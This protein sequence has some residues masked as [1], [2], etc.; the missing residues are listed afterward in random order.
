MT[1]T[2][3]VID[4]DGRTLTVTVLGKNARGTHVTADVTLEPAERVIA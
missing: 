1:F 4:T 2:G 3:K